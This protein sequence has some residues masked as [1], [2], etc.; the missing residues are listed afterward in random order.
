MSG[1]RIITA[2]TAREDRK[3]GS[4]PLKA[5][6]IEIFAILDAMRRQRPYGGVTRPRARVTMMISP[7]M[8]GLIL[9]AAADGRMIGQNRIIAGTA[10][11]K[12]PMKRKNITTTIR[13]T[14]LPPGMETK[15]DCTIMFS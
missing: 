5:S 1:N 13:N 2:S 14:V 8:I 15:K 10:S 4:V 6:S 3:Y 12:V 11:M 9:S 7:R